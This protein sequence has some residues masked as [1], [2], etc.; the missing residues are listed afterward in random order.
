MLTGRS[1][2]WSSYESFVHVVDSMVNQH[3]KWLEATKREIPWRAPISGL[4]ILLS[5][6]VW[7]Q[8]HNGFSHQDPGFIDLLLNKA[9]DTHIVNAYY[10]AD[11]NMALAVAE[12][13]YQST[14]C[15]NAIFCGKQPAPTFQ[16]VDEA[17]SEL[18]EGVATWEWASTADS[19]AEADVVVATC[20]D[21]PTLEA[22]AATDMLRELGIKVWFVNVVDLLKI[23][24]ACENDQ[25]ISDERWAELFGCGEKPGPLRVPRLCRHDSPPD[26]E[27]PRP[28]RLPRPRLRGERL[29]DNAVRH[30]APEQHGPLGTGRRRAAHGRRR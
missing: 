15:V 10:P 24:N 4:N 3:C 13:V 28:R 21:V 7:R 11:A 22:L 23:Q 25:A 1:G 29:H 16:T 20:G 19:L 5:S 6:H 12:R 30:A 27:P 18:A 17:K 14:D 2:V 26:L 8:D 9:N